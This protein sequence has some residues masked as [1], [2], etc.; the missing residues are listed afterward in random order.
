MV[1][2]QESSVEPVSATQ[3]ASDLLRVLDQGLQDS[4]AGEIA[5]IRQQVESLNDRFDGGEEPA[6]SGD[7][8]PEKVKAAMTEVFID[9]GLLET[10]VRRVLTRELDATGGNGGNP[11]NRD[12]IRK[13]AGSLVKD[14]LAENLGRIF[15]EQIE[16][17]VEQSVSQFL[18]SERVKELIDEKFRAVTLYMQT[19]VIPKAVEQSLQDA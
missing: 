10:L 19:E 9:S 1:N 3:V 14:F 4:L 11:G 13:I 18:S 2:T 5:A 16:G 12:E 15:N 6:S 7:V 17:V 8:S